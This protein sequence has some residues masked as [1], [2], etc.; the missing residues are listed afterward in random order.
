MPLAAENSSN[1]AF[2][3]KVSSWAAFNL[4]FMSAQPLI[5]DR[6]TTGSFDYIVLVFILDHGF[7]GVLALGAQL[8]DTLFEPIAG[9]AGRIVFRGSLQLDVYVS[10]LRSLL[11]QR[12]PDI[13]TQSRFRLRKLRQSEI[14]LGSLSNCS[15]A[16]LSR[17]SLVSGGV[18]AIGPNLRT[19]RSKKTRMSGP[20]K[21]RILR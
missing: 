1:L 18:S 10:R 9:S 15:T 16:K 17:S 3:L 11:R 7:L 12:D 13:L 14:R 6:P 8:R 2:A 20:N 21:S 4:S 5:V 19:K